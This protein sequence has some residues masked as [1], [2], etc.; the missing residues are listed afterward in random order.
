[1][2]GANLI[3]FYRAAA[4]FLIRL[5]QLHDAYDERPVGVKLFRVA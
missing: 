2:Q 3:G 5:A 1:L 4:A